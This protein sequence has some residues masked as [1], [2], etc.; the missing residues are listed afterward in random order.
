[1]KKINLGQKEVIHFVGVGGIGMSGLALI[2]KNMGFQIQGS[3]QN[4]NK[5]TI[6]CAKSGIKVFIGHSKNN[7]KSSSILVRSSA[8][9]NNNI[10]I[11]YARKKKIPIFSR[12]EILADVVSLKKNIIIT[13]SHGKTTTTSLVAKILS[14]QKLDPTIING[15]VINSFKTNAKFGNGEWAILEAD[16][17][18]GSFL[19]LPINYSIVTNIDYE[20]IDFYKNFKNLEKSFIK[21][22]EKTPP[23]GKSIICIDNRN[24]KKIFGK[25]KNKNIITYGESKNSNYKISNIRF[26][27]DYSIFDISYRDTRKKIKKIKNIKLRL[28][29]KHNVLNAVA[30]I[31]V[32]LNIGVN[33]N[34][35]KQSLKNFSGV[36]RRMTKIF[37]KNGNDFYDDYA[38]HPTEITSILDS[39]KNVYNARKLISVFEPHRYS[40]VLSLSKN[41]AK[42]FLKSDLVLLCPLYAAGEKKTSKFNTI[43]FA[44]LI[45]KLSKTEVILI[46]NQ[47]QLGKFLK[48]N[49]IENEIVIGMGAGII[50]KWM[51]NLKN[52]I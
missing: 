13:G 47:I 29:G 22:I 49:L 50:S 40:R 37:S 36:Q 10:E 43:K 7:V 11:K 28:L 31:I 24:I 34:I 2:M 25:I 21:F 44:N 46:N 41:F 19:K 35:V 20:H 33:Q 9:K 27:I 48:K 5:N 4:K 23:T 3:D 45:S 17:S 26:R 18:D 12:A 14:D 1:M 15:G 30:A 42:C 16:E 52:L 8:I 39:V 51:N 32:C 6:T 38:H